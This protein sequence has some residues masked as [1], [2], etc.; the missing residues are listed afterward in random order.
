MRQVVGYGLKLICFGIILTRG[1]IVSNDIVNLREYGFIWEGS[2]N[3]GLL[4]WVG[5]RTCPLGDYLD[6]GN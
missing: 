3:E 6:Y 1:G 5:P 2:L 4:G